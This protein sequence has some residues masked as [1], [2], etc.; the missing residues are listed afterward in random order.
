PLVVNSVVVSGDFAQTNTCASNV[1]AGSSCTISVT[2]TP[3]VLGAD[4]GV[5][6]ITDNASGSPQSVSL[7]GNG[8]SAGAPMASLSPASLNFPTQIL[9]TASATQTVT[10]TNTGT[11]TLT[12]S[13]ISITGTN[14]SD[15]S[16]INTCSSVAPAGNCTISVTFDPTA[17]GKRTA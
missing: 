11:A 2:F 3:T 15:Y 13:S 4:S 8:T 9:N 16:Q 7:S 6:T 17:I 1:P 10:L 12:V 14:S 5:I